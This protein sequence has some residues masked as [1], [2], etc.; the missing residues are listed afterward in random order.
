MSCQRSARFNNATI[1]PV[2]TR[3]SA[4]MTLADALPDDLTR[5]LRVAGI[6]FNRSEGFRGGRM[7]TPLLN[8]IVLVGTVLLE[9]LLRGQVQCLGERDL[10]AARFALQSRSQL[11]GDPPAVHFG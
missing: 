7:E 6:A 5:I 10:P 8:G 9:P 3:A 2:S 1:A 4:T 11:R